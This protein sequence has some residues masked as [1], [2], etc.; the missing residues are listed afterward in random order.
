[1]TCISSTRR[2]KNPTKLTYKSKVDILKKRKKMELLVLKKK[3]YIEYI[4]HKIKHKKSKQTNK[5]YL[6]N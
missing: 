1:M 6:I 3:N 2:K 5:I 4:K